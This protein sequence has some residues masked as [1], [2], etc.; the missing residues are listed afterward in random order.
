MKKTYYFESH[1]VP[2]GRIFFKTLNKAY[3]WVDEKQRYCLISF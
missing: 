1:D 2:I 3:H